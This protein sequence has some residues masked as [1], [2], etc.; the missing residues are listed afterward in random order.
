MQFVLLTLIVGV[1]NLCVGYGLGACLGCGPT[2]LRHARRGLP[3]APSAAAPAGRGAVAAGGRA[4]DPL[5]P[6]GLSPHNPTDCEEATDNRDAEPELPVLEALLRIVSQSTPQLAKLHRR[7]ARGRAGQDT[8]SAWNFVAELQ[9]VC[10]PYMERL[11]NLVA[12]LDECGNP[13]GEPALDGEMQEAVLEQIAQLETTLSN[14]QHMDFDSGFSA[15]MKRLSAETA[16]TLGVAK[17]LQAALLTASGAAA[18]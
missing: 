3:K 18:V 8:R 5:E 13:G 10:Q 9:G 11:E 12:R 6:P 17:R 1:V 16:S 4:P 2:P 14:L 7:L 15:A